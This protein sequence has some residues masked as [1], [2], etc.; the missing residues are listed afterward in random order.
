MVYLLRWKYD[1]DDLWWNYVVCHTR[2][3]ALNK[4]HG[5]VQRGPAQLFELELDKSKKISAVE[6]QTNNLT[7]YTYDPEESG[8]TAR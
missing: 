3:A 7:T 1:E 2:E 4:L 8:R 5:N 6:I